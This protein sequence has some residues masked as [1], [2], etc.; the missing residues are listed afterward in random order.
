MPEIEALS[1]L[2]E[3][4]EAPLASNGKRLLCNATSFHF[5]SSVPIDRPL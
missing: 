1:F 4:S 3:M 5:G 2:T